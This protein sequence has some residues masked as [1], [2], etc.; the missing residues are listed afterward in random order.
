MTQIKQ[1]SELTK[2]E[3]IEGRYEY[4]KLPGIL[5]EKTFGTDRYLNQRFYQ[6]IEW[7]RIRDFVIVRDDGC[8]LGVLEFPIQD[9]ILIHHMNPVTIKDLKFKNIDVLDPNFLI[10]TSERTHNAIHYGDKSLLPY[11]PKQRTPG[12]TKLW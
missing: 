5:G 12:D 1:Y 2:I 4:L 9:R 6:L 8:D 7:K 3:T 11:V 10:S